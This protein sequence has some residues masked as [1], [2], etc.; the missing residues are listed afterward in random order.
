M[1]KAHLI[2][3]LLA[4]AASK[5][6]GGGYGRG[7]QLADRQCPDTDGIERGGIPGLVER[8]GRNLQAGGRVNRWVLRSL[9]CIEQV[10]GQPRV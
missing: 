10:R 3:N 6:S 1:R 7:I 8:G 4:Q 2:T 5:G 9:A